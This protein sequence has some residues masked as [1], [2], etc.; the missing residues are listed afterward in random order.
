MPDPKPPPPFEQNI[1]ESQLTK[2][3]DEITSGSFRKYTLLKRY[4]DENGFTCEQAFLYT[5]SHRYHIIARYA[6]EEKDTYLGMTVTTRKSRTGERHHRGNDLADGKMSQETWDR[7][8]N[9]IIKYEL[10][11]LDIQTNDLADPFGDDK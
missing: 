1:E 7:M 2:W 8:K 5:K 10:K 4:Q 3:L 9:D 6:V 11:Q